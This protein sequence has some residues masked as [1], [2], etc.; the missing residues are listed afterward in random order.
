MRTWIAATLMA[1]GGRGSPAAAR[2]G[3]K[4]SLRAF[5]SDPCQPVR[6][7]NLGGVI[8]YCKGQCP[9]EP[10]SCGRLVSR[11]ARTGGPWRDDDGSAYDVTRAYRCRC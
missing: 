6:E 5:A 10:S 1:L 3:V 9:G 11:A 4:W 7:Q 8:V 2:Q